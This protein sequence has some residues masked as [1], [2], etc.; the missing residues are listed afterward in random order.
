[1]LGQARQRQDRV[2]RKCTQRAIKLQTGSTRLSEAFVDGG[3]PTAT[4]SC[5]RP[6]HMPSHTDL[7]EQATK[8]FKLQT[9]SPR[10][11]RSCVGA[12]CFAAARACSHAIEE[13]TFQTLPL[14]DASRQSCCRQ[15]A[16]DKRFRQSVGRK[17]SC[18]GTSKRGQLDR[19]AAE[20]CWGT[21]SMTGSA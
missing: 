15:A 19:K 8:P 4:A 2:A 1:M 6:N 13:M 21:R 14:E 10:P 20:R 5:C 17:I 18:V 16:Q 3:R 9:G 11:Q 12:D 7:L